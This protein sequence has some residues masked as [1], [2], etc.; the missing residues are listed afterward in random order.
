LVVRRSTSVTLPRTRANPPV[1]AISAAIGSAAAVIA[2]PILIAS[3]TVPRTVAPRACSA[4]IVYSAATADPPNSTAAARASHSS[5]APDIARRTITLPRSSVITYGL[6][7]IPARCMVTCGTSGKARP[8][9][10]AST[11]GS[12]IRPAQQTGSRP[13]DPPISAGMKA[14]TLRPVICSR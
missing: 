8:M 2:S 5:H 3:E 4:V 10:S 1:A 12:P 6:G 7:E 14:A 9:P 11:T 13:F